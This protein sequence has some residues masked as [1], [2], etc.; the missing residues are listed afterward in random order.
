[1]DVAGKRILVVGASGALGSLIAKDLMSLG[2][3]VL[4]TATTNESATR[5]PAGLELNLLLNLESEKS[6]AELSAYINS[7]GIDGVILASGVVAFGNT[8]ELT[9]KTLDR[10]MDVNALGQIKLLIAIQKALFESGN[11]F[12]L[13]I[14][15]V[16]AEA[17][18]PGMA[19]YSASKTALQG[20]LTAITREWRRRGVTVI[21]ARPGHTETGLAT[22]SISGVAPAF[23][24]GMEPQVVARRLVTAI[25]HDEKE[26]PASA[27]QA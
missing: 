20:F 23:P 3:R 6:I 14:P 8:D 27:F 11:A 25:Q 12:V 21:S 18:L 15:G 7:T 5:L 17:P 16:V 19:A 13:A 2:A 24:A 10:L 22:R 9:P 26:L 4:G 1:M